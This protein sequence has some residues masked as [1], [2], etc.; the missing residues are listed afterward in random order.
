MGKIRSAWEIALERT[1][2]IEVD[3][4]RLAHN[5]LINKAKAITSLFINGED[6]TL[7]D[8]VKAL[9][10]LNDSKA[11]YEGAIPAILQ[12]ITLPIGDEPDQRAGKAKSLMDFISGNNEAVSAL[13]GQIVAF[14]AQ[15]PEHKKQLIEQ[16]KAQAEPALREKEAKLRET[17]GDDIHLTL[18]QDKDFLQLANKN[19][20]HLSE[21][22]NRTLDGAKAQLKSYFNLD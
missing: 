20:E 4:E 10:E 17:Y 14:L 16:L 1:E 13:T 2:N 6:K 15:Y 9:Y 19:L 12:S 21:Q 8:T 3:K 7:E 18:E 11:M 5:E 22:Y